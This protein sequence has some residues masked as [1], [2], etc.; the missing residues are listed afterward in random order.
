MA[1]KK[2]AQISD[3]EEKRR[4]LDVRIQY[5][6]DHIAR[7]EQ[8]IAGMENDPSR[9]DLV[10]YLWMDIGSYERDIDGYHAEL[11]RLNNE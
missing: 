7:T 11:D 9:R 1:R 5:A 8:R 4:W 6:R 10:R 3:T 2:R